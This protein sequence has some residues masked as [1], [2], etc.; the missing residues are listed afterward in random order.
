MKSSARAASDL[1]GPHTQLSSYEEDEWVGVGSL[2]NKRD[3]SKDETTCS[4]A[5]QGGFT[6]ENCGLGPLT[7]QPWSDV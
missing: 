7:G 5:C 3:K 6:L 1:R 2:E 4:M